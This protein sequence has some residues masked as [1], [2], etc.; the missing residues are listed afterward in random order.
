MQIKGLLGPTIIFLKWERVLR[1]KS[2]RNPA[3]KYHI[4]WELD[5]YL[6]QGAN[7]LFKCSTTFTDG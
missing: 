7:D 5:H 6:K 3:L 2:L 1:A 4:F